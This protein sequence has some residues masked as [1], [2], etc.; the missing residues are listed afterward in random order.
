MPEIDFS[1][2]GTKPPSTEGGEID[3]S[4]YPAKK[5][6]PEGYIDF[7]KYS[8]QKS[9]PSLWDKV[10]SFASEAA[11]NTINASQDEAK[12]IANPVSNVLGGVGNV[13]G[14]VGNTVAGEGTALGE[15]VQPIKKAIETGNWNNNRTAARAP[16]EAP[17]LLKF[18]ALGLEDIPAALPDKMM[19]PYGV[20]FPG[21]PGLADVSGAKNAAIG[22]IQASEELA[23]GFTTPTN[24]AILVASGGASAIP[25]VVGTVART[26]IPAYFAY[27]MG[28]GAV[29]QGKNYYNLK[30]QQLALEEEDKNAPPGEDPN[31]KQQRKNAIAQLQQ[32][33]AKA[34]AHSAGNVLM[35]Q[36]AVRHAVQALPSSPAWESNGPEAREFN[37]LPPRQKT[38]LP[39]SEV[40]NDIISKSLAQR[41]STAQESAKAFDEQ[42]PR[43]Q[44]IYP[45]N[46]NEAADSL[47]HLYNRDRTQAAQAAARAL[48]AN[49]FVPETGESNAEELMALDK[50]AQDVAQ[51]PFDKLSPEDQ[52]AVRQLVAEGYGKAVQ[53]K[54]EAAPSLPPRITPTPGKPM[55]GQPLDEAQVAELYGVAKQEEPNQPEQSSLPPRV[56][57]EQVPPR[58]LVPYVNPEGEKVYEKVGDDETPEYERPGLNYLPPKLEKAVAPYTGE[59][60]NQELVSGLHIEPIPLEGADLG[61][62]IA[63]TASPQTIEM[64]GRLERKGGAG[65]HGIGLHWNPS[66]IASKLAGLK[67]I[68][69]DDLHRLSIAAKEAMRAGKSFIL[70]NGNEK[71]PEAV[72]ATALQEELNHAAQ[73]ALHGT[74]K[75]TNFG[76]AERHISDR[77]RS[78]LDDTSIIGEIAFD[79]LQEGGYFRGAVDPGEVIAEI[80]VRMM[81]PGRLGELGLTTEQARSWAATY[82]KTLREE[83]GHEKPR[84]IAQRVFD[85][86]RKPGSKKPDNATTGIR[87]RRR[88]GTAQNARSDL[89]GDDNAGARASAKPVAAEPVSLNEALDKQEELVAPRPADEAQGSLFYMMTPEEQA[90]SSEIKA[91]TDKQK[92]AEARTKPQRTYMEA[93]ANLK[94]KWIDNKS[95]FEDTVRSNAI[96]AKDVFKLNPSDEP[97]MYLDR[98][99]KAG[100]F[101]K[102]FINKDVVEYSPEVGKLIGATPDANGKFTTT[103][104]L[105]SLIQSL[106][107]TEQEYLDQYMI[108]KR[109]QATGQGVGGRDQAADKKVIDTLKAKYDPLAKEVYAYNDAVLQQAIDFGLINKEAGKKLRKDHGEYVSIE[110]I[111]EMIDEA[112]GDFKDIGRSRDNKVPPVT[113]ALASTA[114]QSVVKGFTKEG[115]V[116]ENQI[117]SPL[118]AS[119]AKT[120]QVFSQGLQNE[121]ARGMVNSRLIPGM[122]NYFTEVNPKSMR[123]LEGPEKGKE[124]KAGDTISYLDNGQKKT[125]K[126]TPEFVNVAKSLD[127]YQ[128]SLME[129]SL[130]NMAQY[131]KTGTVG[132]NALFAAKN[133]AKDSVERYLNTPTDIRQLT[134]QGLRAG[135]VKDSS[136][137]SQLHMRPDFA[138]NLVKSL[139]AAFGHG[140]EYQRIHELVGSDGTTFDLIN[141]NAQETL[142]SVSAQK[143]W[144]T[145][146]KYIVTKNPAKMGHR[147]ATQMAHLVSRTEEA[148]RIQAFM[149]AEKMALKAG[150]DKTQAAALG[151]KAYKQFTGEFTRGGDYRRAIGYFQVFLNAATQGTRSSIQAMERDPGGY[152]T[153]L[154]ATV[155]IPAAMTTAWN[156]S[157]EKRRKV[158][159]DLQPYYKD[160]SLFLIMDDE[161]GKDNRYHVWSV[162]TRGTQELG[163]IVARSMYAAYKK[164]PQ[165]ASQIFGDMVGAISPI[166]ASPGGL[167]LMAL[168]QAVGG[169]AAVAFNKDPFTGK[170][171]VPDYMSRNSSPNERSFDS[172]SATAKALASGVNKMGGAV[173]P[174]QMDY[175]AK[176]YGGSVM[177][178]IMNAA[179]TAIAIPAAKTASQF[180]DS[181]DVKRIAESA[182]GG[183]TM[184]GAFTRQFATAPGGAVSDI[185]RGKTAAVREIVGDDKLPAQRLVRQIVDNF[186]TGDK[187]TALQLYEDGMKS[188]VI[189]ANV[190]KSLDSRIKDVEAGL[191]PW[192]SE[193]KHESLAVKAERI[194]QIW[195]DTPDNEVDE[196]MDDLE[197]K[198]ILTKAVLAE[199]MKS[200]V[201]SK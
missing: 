5:S 158:Y 56:Q 48:K 114:T 169:L 10:K 171:I 4:Q 86:L 98:A 102:N 36:A 46:I 58:Q 67:N 75:D 136:I 174:I 109:T 51:V 24:A 95:A 156:L 21:S 163:N 186:R 74:E 55:P 32:Q 87:Q 162:P 197:R 52:D 150:Y 143:D 72:R 15:I 115:K 33:S 154:I 38:V 88:E 198:G 91:A 155:L 116:D 128:M 160:K 37:P 18:D 167:P 144:K 41:P 187:A 64:I 151:E 76:A 94:T 7:S 157:D 83:Y 177:P 29:A 192:E 70:I 40:V 104:S 82:V 130:A 1:Q 89:S 62:A 12:A 34:F 152:A 20:G 63:Y 123:I 101:G 108:A 122:E 105:A 147:F 183:T 159:E 23:S 146:A 3:F 112:T 69:N 49:T 133:Y 182:P 8:A 180:T 126:T 153:R 188:G 42:I 145:K 140:E 148:N 200:K 17:P 53:L 195:K 161:K 185:E 119:L 120:Y 135:D 61:R 165:L 54:L 181:K 194:K 35:T 191:A 189:D 31:V 117:K 77:N 103:R 25:G 118:N 166:A 44:G 97:H 149:D 47:E 93:L 6:A 57:P 132:V 121:A 170:Q 113:K 66:Q 60:S 131:F 19:I 85:A 13:L 59:M 196:L 139:A 142:E 30:R 176:W 107:K 27:E 81:V 199:I 45:T 73:R 127:V 26:A 141:G 78:D 138:V 179:D 137:L 106:S 193:L 100:N 2:Y 168:P 28:K 90:V 184:A 129:K 201:N 124:V 43:Q 79:K 22:G 125:F 178:Q 84:E 80:A 172:T 173:A 175:L 11:K 111:R 110:R 164:N 65:D 16:W 68:F 50:V 99:V 39:A 134:M 14:R 71:I 190:E 9:E 96:A 92:E